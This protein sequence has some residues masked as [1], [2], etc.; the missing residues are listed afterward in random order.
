MK[1]G[2]LSTPQKILL[3]SAGDLYYPMRV[4][5]RFFS[6]LIGRCRCAR[7]KERIFSE[8]ILEEGNYD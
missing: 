5:E 6:Y 4:D 3:A 1:T 7:R 8:A 2:I